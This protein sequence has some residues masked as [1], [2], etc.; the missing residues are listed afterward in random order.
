M[1]DVLERFV[2]YCRIPS[3]SNPLT[4]DVVPSTP[5]Q[6]DM[7]R[8]VERGEV[9]APSPQ[10]DGVHA[11][12]DVHAH[13]VRARLVDNC[14]GGADSASHA[15]MNIGHDADFAFCK[16]LDVTYS[17]YLSRRSCFH[18][19]NEAAGRIEFSLYFYHIYHSQFQVFYHLFQLLTERSDY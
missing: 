10:L 1:S 11:A 7:A 12:A 19:I 4:A 15:G 17:F 5:E 6:F 14:H 2:R 9:D 16:S 3:Q 13:D 8:V 18:L